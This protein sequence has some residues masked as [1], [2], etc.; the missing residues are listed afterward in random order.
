MVADLDTY[1][2]GRPAHQ[3]NELTGALAGKNVIMIMVE[4]L[5]S[6]MLNDAFMPTLSA[7]AKDSLRFDH[8]Y[9]PL[10]L[11]AGTFSTEFTSQTGVIP[12]ISGVSTDAYVE[13]ALP[14]ALP[15]LFAQEGYR[16]NSYHSASPTIYNRGAI[17]KNLGFESYHSHVE[18]G[19]QDYMIDSQL[20]N[21]FDLIVDRQQPFYS[22]IITYSGHG[23]YTDEYDN[24]AQPH[25]E[26]AKQAVAASGVTGSEDTMEQFTRAVAQ[27]M[28]TDD[29]IGGLVDRLEEAGLLEDTVLVIYGDHYCKY[30]T[31]TDFLLN[32]KGVGSRNLLCNTP[33]LIY[34]PGLSPR[35]VEKYGST[36]DLYPTI[37]NL[38]SLNADLRY[39]VGEDLFSDG[40]GL[41][42]WRDGSFY[43]GTEYFDASQSASGAERDRYYEV[44]NR[45]DMSWKTFRYNY[46]L[47]TDPLL[48]E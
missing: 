5:D 30:L 10:Y 20:L 45:L 23:S 29:F 17:H 6:W 36:V 22:F 3:D 21:G 25:M 26:Q 46:F 12:P 37:C 9:T 41:V 8:F 11:N 28:V 24:I 14:A 35:T 43:D 40:E 38:F 18:M 27:I 7:L 48:A 16:V 31:D 42:Y 33:L 15:A 13:N 1:F 4:S 19:M 44:R 47:Y 2:S 39:F 32:L 34:N